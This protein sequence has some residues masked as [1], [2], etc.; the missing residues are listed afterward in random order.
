MEKPLGD[1]ASTWAVL[2]ASNSER[3]EPLATGIDAPSSR[4]LIVGEHRDSRRV[5]RS[6]RRGPALDLPVVGFV[7]AG[8]AGYVGPL[9]R[10]R[11][12]AIHPQSEPVPVL[13]RID[14]LAELVD[15]A[16]ATHLV[17]TLTGKSRHRIRRQLEIVSKSNLHV[18]W[19]AEDPSPGS[20]GIA[21]AAWTIAQPSFGRRRHR[22]AKRAIDI[23]GALF[24]L[25]V[26][27]PLFAVIALAILITSGR[28]ILYTQERVGRGGRLF[29]MHK[30][31]SMRP[32]AEGSTGPIWASNRDDRCTR[33]GAWLRRTNIDELPQLFNVL[34]GEMSLV[35]PRPE[36]PVFVE[37]F[38]ETVPD[39]D[40]RHAMPGGMTGWAQ[41][42]GWRGRTSL[43]KRVQYDLDYI[44]RWSFWI[45]FRV[46][47]MTFEHVVFGRTSW[48][49]GGRTPRRPPA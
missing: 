15:Q 32:D 27:S 44:Q 19:L 9:A 31:R 20:A 26:L 1:R 38:R 37:K 13:G 12:L 29:R 7:D 24:G 47:L 23:L 28:P 14:R 34:R 21:P 3:G 11:Q 43:R 10:G 22:I 8:H 42:H 17:I 16:K 2:G 25:T 36:R 18:L 5:A 40:L 39:Y 30:F 6:L 49:D 48:N 46:L 41:V 35:G 4:A 33:I 45:D